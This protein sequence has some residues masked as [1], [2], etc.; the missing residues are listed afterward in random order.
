MTTNNYEFEEPGLLSPIAVGVPGKRTFFLVIGEKED[1]IRLWLE[2]EHLEALSI[3]VDE[4]LINISQD[5]PQLPDEPDTPPA[6]DDTP[7]GFPSGEYEIDQI[8][9]GY[10]QE[11]V[12]IEFLVHALGPQDLDGIPVHCWINPGILQRLGNQSRKICAAG[13]PRC[14]L[15]GQPID[16]TGHDCP[17]QN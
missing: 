12:V 16:P 7:S 13:R 3:A 17:M 10:D 5:L 6:N 9:I 15:C 14:K 2:K 4:F 11:K 1:W 8:G